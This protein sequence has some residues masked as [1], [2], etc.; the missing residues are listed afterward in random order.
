MKTN[1]KMIALVIALSMA[2]T[3]CASINDAESSSA[4]ASYGASASA[5]SSA[6][7]L[8]IE[9]VADTADDYTD[10]DL[11]Q[12]ADTDV[13]QEITVSDGQTVTITQA[14]TYILS[15]TASNCTVRV[16]ADKENDKIQIVLNGVSITNE[17]APAIYVVSA[18]KC[19]IT[20]AE[21][22]ENSLAVTG[23]FTA[24]G[25]TNTDAV[26]YSKD[27]LVLNGL[28]SLDIS[29]SDN[30]ISCKDDLKVTG[31]SYTI[32]SSSDAVEAN[33]SILICDGSFVINTG[34]DAF[35]AENDEDNTSGCIE[36]SGG[37]FDIN[38]ASDGI[39]GTSC[40]S[41][42]DTGVVSQD[43]RRRNDDHS[44]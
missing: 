35:H 4:D 11:E 41:E 8:P 32:T 38:A 16:E 39:Q 37:T 2:A 19:F 25:D 12:T 30:G 17:S 1:I 27:D 3:G 44:R 43:R 42:Q 9:N 10:R 22:T 29:S 14:G 20:T 5:D 31:G 24:D 18:D 7:S 34:K 21:G 13:S 26:I 15:G 33:D 36:I 40:F 28:G 23:S 6:S